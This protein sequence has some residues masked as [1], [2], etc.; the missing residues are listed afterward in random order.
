MG[1][2]LLAV[3]IILII[4]LGWVAVQQ[5]ARLFAARHPEFGPYTEKTGCCGGRGRD[6]GGKSCSTS[7]ADDT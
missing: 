3:G 2:Y 4:M 6:C 1:T 7:A 5:M